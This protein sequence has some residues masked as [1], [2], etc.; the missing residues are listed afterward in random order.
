MPSWYQ[1]IGISS[2]HTPYQTSGDEPVAVMLCGAQPEPGPRTIAPST[3]SKLLIELP[4]M[5][6]EATAEMFSQ[7]QSAT[8]TGR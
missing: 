2:Q 4:P 8:G 3:S 7:G 5:V 1:V 6:V